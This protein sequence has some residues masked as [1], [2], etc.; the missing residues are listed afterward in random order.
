VRGKGIKLEIIERIFSQREVGFTKRK[1]NSKKLLRTRRETD[2]VYTRDR[3]WI[4]GLV[5][6]E[7]KKKVFSLCSKLKRKAELYKEG[8][9]RWIKG[10]GTSNRLM[11]AS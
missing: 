10:G 4:F 11:I 2:C 7:E 3:Q 9:T 1:G 6:S 5:D 8:E